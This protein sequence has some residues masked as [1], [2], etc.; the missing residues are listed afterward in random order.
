MRRKIL[1]VVWYVFI[2]VA[3]RYVFNASPGDAFIGAMI[4]LCLIDI[5]DAIREKW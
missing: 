2:Y 1:S 5:A 4:C 3:A